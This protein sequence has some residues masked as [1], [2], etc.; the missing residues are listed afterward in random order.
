MKFTG[1]PEIDRPVGL[2]LGLFAGYIT[3]LG[4]IKIINGIKAVSDAQEEMDNARRSQGFNT[5]IAGIIEAS[6]GA[7]VVFLGFNVAF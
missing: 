2:L 4:I 7:I 6:A 1:I 5:L 3:I